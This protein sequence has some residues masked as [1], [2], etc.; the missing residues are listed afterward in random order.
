MP[1][2]SLESDHKVYHRI[3]L[4]GHIAISIL[5][6]IPGLHRLQSFLYELWAKVGDGM[7]G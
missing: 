5:R 4:Q 1:F 6:T 7:K 2:P 3:L